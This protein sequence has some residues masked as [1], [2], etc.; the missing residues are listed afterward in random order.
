MIDGGGTGGFGTGEK[1]D[2]GGEYGAAAQ[3]V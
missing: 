2:E 1:C 3:G